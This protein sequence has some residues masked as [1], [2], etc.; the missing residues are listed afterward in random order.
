MPVTWQLQGSIVVIS[1]V[2]E[3]PASELKHA[4]V[5]AATDSHF[6]KGAPILFDA[7][8]SQVN[9]LP[10]DVEQRVAMLRTLPDR[11]YANRAAV[12]LGSELY[13]FGIARMLQMQLEIHHFHLEIFR[14]RDE[15]LRWLAQAA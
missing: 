15:A 11:G 9:L 14:D 6:H 5:D 13:K 2:G 8:E 4:L 10:N 12:L 1:A 3:Y 7:R